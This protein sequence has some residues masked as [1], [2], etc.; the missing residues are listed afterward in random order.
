MFIYVSYVF[1]LYKWIIQTYTNICLNIL[2]IILKPISKEK[3]FRKKRTMLNYIFIQEFQIN[4]LY[5]NIN[6][7]NLFQNNFKIKQNKLY[8]KNTILNYIYIYNKIFTIISSKK[9]KIDL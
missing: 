8:Y 7:L 4:I 2:R 5:L 9:Y 6:K 1:S 3:L